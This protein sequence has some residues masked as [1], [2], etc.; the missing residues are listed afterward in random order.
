MEDFAKHKTYGRQYWCK[1]CMSAYHG[2]RV[3]NPAQ[4]REYSLRKKYG[5]TTEAFEALVRA[6]RGRC[7]V[8]R[9]PET[10]VFGG[11]LSVD[12]DHATGAVRGLLCNYCNRGAGFFRDNA[13]LLRK[14]A[15][16]LEAK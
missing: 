14:M 2:R 5:L 11:R 6:Q 4:R 9:K 7:A 3:R 12:H 13:K 1:E 16:Y 8:C 10:K 15:A